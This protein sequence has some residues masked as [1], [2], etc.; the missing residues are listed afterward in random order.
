MNKFG[1]ILLL[2]AISFCQAEIDTQIDINAIYDYLVIV[3]KGFST[4]NNYQCS[5]VL[6][7]K[8][9]EIL[10]IINQLLTEIENG[11]KLSDLAFSYGLKLLAVDGMGDKCKAL[12]VIAK[13]LALITQ[14][15]IKDTGYRIINN[16]GNIYN[17][18]TEFRDAA[19]LNGK[20]VAAGK[21]IRY[22]IGIETL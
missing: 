4:T 14:Q 5:A 2:L 15:G 7:S 22:S 18:V 8:K 21:I 17:A 1:L 13:L 9:T 10:D 19:D 20:L 6:N 16:S 3:A 11:K 12:D